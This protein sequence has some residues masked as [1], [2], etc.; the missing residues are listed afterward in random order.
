VA[1]LDLLETILLFEVTEERR[2]T[3]GNQE[4]MVLSDSEE[5][6]E[7]QENKDQ[8]DLQVLMEYRYKQELNF[9][10]SSGKT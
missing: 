5:N 9:Y 1:S 7:H 10:F 8:E 2:E 3:Q 4:R 6:K